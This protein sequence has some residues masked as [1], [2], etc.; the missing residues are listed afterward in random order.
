MEKASP[1]NL[2]PKKYSVGTKSNPA[3]FGYGINIIFFLLKKVFFLLMLELWLDRRKLL[4]SK[5]K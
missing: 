4:N 3:H 2:Y 5:D 1:I